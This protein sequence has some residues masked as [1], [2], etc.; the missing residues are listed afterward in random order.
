MHHAL[1]F[2]RL[3]DWVVDGCPN[4]KAVGSKPVDI[5]FRKGANSFF[6]L[7]DGT[8]LKYDNNLGAVFT[9]NK[10]T[11][12]P[13]IASHKYIFFGQ[14]DVTVRAARGVG[15]VTSF[16]LQSDDL[17]E[18]DWEWL[19]GDL[20]RVQTN[21][22][23]K[24]CTE[25]YDRGGFSPVADPINQFHTYTIKWT[26]TQLDWLIDGVVVRTLM[27]TGVQGCAGYPQ[28]PMQIKLGTWVAGRKDAPQGTIEWAGGLANFGDIPFDGYYQSL[29]IV[30][31]MGGQG[32]TEA[33][34]YHYT[35]R[36]GSWQSIKVVNNGEES[37][38][39]ST[40]K[41]S[42]AKPTG[43][44]TAKPSSS[45]TTLATLS[46][47]HS[48]SS[49]GTTT[50]TGSSGPTGTSGNQVSS[51]TTG[52]TSVSTGAAPTMVGNMAAIGAAALLGYLAL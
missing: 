35:D 22:F 30:D 52:A 21:F 42:T 36:T 40:S 14:V 47:S 25:T 4:P 39:S 38:S 48:V 1:E 51:T 32:A 41:S 11:D 43:S 15:I 17:D 2:M 50:S 19:G 33:T 7:A 9:I 13:T 31:Y 16:V 28:S 3:T 5:D 12:A 45:A 49:N 8:S 24:G 34:E 29:R 20:A 37:D 27:N 18:I 6:K 44:T 23:S 10:E 26:P 46:T